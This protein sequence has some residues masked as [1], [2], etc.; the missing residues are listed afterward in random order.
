MKLVGDFVPEAIVKEK[1]YPQQTHESLYLQWFR[2]D[3]K[4]YADVYASI[5]GLEVDWEK[6]FQ[7]IPKYKSANNNSK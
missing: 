7:K 6:R 4:R 2:M 1:W 5:N 3:G